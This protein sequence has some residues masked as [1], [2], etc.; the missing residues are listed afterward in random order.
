V[1][2]DLLVKEVILLFFLSLFQQ[3]A[4]SFNMFF[5]FFRTVVGDLITLFTLVLLRHLGGVICVWC[6]LLLC[7]TLCPFV[8]KMGSNFLFEPRLYF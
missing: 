8:T 1:C 6:L 2:A 3:A 5:V 7:F 4:Y